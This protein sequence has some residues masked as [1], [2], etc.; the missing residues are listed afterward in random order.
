METKLTKAPSKMSGEERRAIF[1][2]EYQAVLSKMTPNVPA[3]RPNTFFFSGQQRAYA[4]GQAWKR[5]QEAGF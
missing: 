2:A 1:L 3:L 4:K 5:M